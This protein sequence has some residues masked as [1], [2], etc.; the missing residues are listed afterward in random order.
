MAPPCTFPFRLHAILEQI[1]DTDADGEACIVSWIPPGRSFRIHDL[2]AFEKR[3]L[4][5]YFPCQSKCKSFRRQLQYYGFVNH[6]RGHFSHPFFVQKNKELLPQI[7]HRGKGDNKSMKRCN[8]PF[9]SA[10]KTPSC[11]DYLLLPE[12]P[13][14]EVARESLTRLIKQGATATRLNQEKQYT[15]QQGLLQQLALH[16]KSTTLVDLRCLR[17]IADAEQQYF[18]MQV[19]SWA[20]PSSSC[21]SLNLAIATRKQ[22][23]L[24]NL[25]LL[26]QLP[27][28][29]KGT[30]LSSMFGL[31]TK[32]KKQFCIPSRAPKTSY[33]TLVIFD[34][35]SH[36]KLL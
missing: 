7:K 2:E 36:C 34:G 3:I 6:G 35:K 10:P 8:S 23:A 4:A 5:K 14:R 9:T 30:R 29:A 19:A 17:A 15:A 21:H 28:N 24:L 22:L 1:S 12:S 11:D 13:T 31:G 16:K 26:S 32:T 20:N 18:A 25:A 33:Q 27:W